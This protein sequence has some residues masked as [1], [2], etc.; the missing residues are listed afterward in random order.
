MTSRP[1]PGIRVAVIDDNPHV[2]WDG[3]TYPVDATFD[4]FLPA[5]LEIGEGV[6][7]I[8]HCVPL[9]VGATRPATLPTDP[10]L[11]IV[12]TAPF[13][14]IAGYLRHAP[15]L[16][17]E[18]LGILRPVI[19]AADLVWIKVPASNALVAGWLAARSGRS[20]VGYVAGSARAVA[21]G[22]RL[23]LA[24]QAVGGAYD[25]AGRLAGGRHR[26]VVGDDI[27]DGPGVVTS[28]VE[29]DEVRDIGGDSW[30]AN[31]AQLRL[32]WAGRV[33]PGKGLEALVEAVAG[34]I[35]ELAGIRVELVLLGDGPGR[36]GIQEQAAAMGIGDRLQWP[37]FIADRDAYLDAL[38][39]ADLFVFPSPAEGFPKVV[40]DAMAVG[41]PVIAT[42]AGSLGEL[43]RAGLIAPTSPSAAGIE[44]AV[45]ALITDGA[46]AT[47]LQ[48]AGLTFAAGH[49]RTAEAR[50]LVRRWRDWFPTLPWPDAP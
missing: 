43:A 42:P 7:S 4:R 45:R 29:A 24:A 33:V 8:V 35:G 21:R 40:L 37:G 46:T 13:E 38:R 3:R 22:R 34:L 28:L 10:R 17:R 36:P 26:I 6:A 49:T 32:A 16:I 5:L 1:R 27:V 15:R 25:L 23:G 50:R 44:S 20:R 12:G 47:R 30:P 11:G 14:G 48:D 2:S 9:R 18:N 41:L 31:P 19:A 39:G